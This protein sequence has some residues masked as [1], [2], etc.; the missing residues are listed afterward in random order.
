[1]A[2]YFT[3]GCSLLRSSREN[4]AF[5]AVV[6]EARSRRIRRLATPFFLS[7]PDICP[8]SVTFLRE[9]VSPPVQRTRALGYF[10]ALFL[11]TFSLSF[12]C[13][14]MVPLGFRE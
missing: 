7:Q 5:W 10:W 1:M 12:S 2:R 14:F 13:C 6:W 4:R 3:S 11:T 9:A 8:A